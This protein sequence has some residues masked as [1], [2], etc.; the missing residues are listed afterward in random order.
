MAST[1]DIPF[2]TIP[3][4]SALFLNYLECSPAA[5]RFYQQ[6]PTFASLEKSIRTR[7]NGARLPRQKVAAILRR[8]NKGYGCDLETLKQIDELENPDCVA[9]V[10]GQQ[11]GLFTGPLYT[12]YKALTA[13]R[14]AQNLRKRG[15]RAV[16]VFWM[17]TEDHDLAEVTRRTVLKSDS[18]LQSID[19]RDILFDELPVG[20]VGSIRFP[21][22]IAQG[23]QKYLDCLPD[24]IGKAETKAQ[25]EAACRPGTSFAQSFAELLSHILAGQGLMLFDPHDP[26]VKRLSSAVFQTALRDGR[27]IRTALVRRNGDLESSGFHSQVNVLDN[28]TV[29]FFIEN[30]ERRALEQRD[31]GF[32]LKNTNRTFGLDELLDYA[33]EAPEKFS[34]NVLL[35]PLVQDHLFPTAAYVGGSAELAYFAQIEVLYEMYDCPMPVLWPRDSFTLIE[36]EIGTEMDRMGIEFPDCFQGKRHLAQKAVHASGYSQAAANLDSMQE[37]L[38]RVLTEIK[39]ELQAVEAPLAQALETARRKILHN[40]QHLKSQVTRFEGTRN[41]SISNSVDLVLTHC[42]PNSNLQE[43]ELGIYHFL[44][45]YGSSLLNDIRSLMETG[46]FEHHVIR[47]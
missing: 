25:I 1:T 11:V 32:G 38:D 22:K 37:R 21:E 5:L 47:L 16:P 14:L 20:S 45:R 44:A 15:I 2:H 13:I 8:Q 41:S 9:I 33:G 12:I 17:E 39:P 46:N 10:T 29:L 35:R 26:E 42:Y 34:P 27:A 30:G 40:V 24:G 7:L 19:F 18:S 3:H 4:Q 23:V 43:R 31:S 6:A 28:S 36:P